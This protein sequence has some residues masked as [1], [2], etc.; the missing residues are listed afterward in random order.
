VVK[1]LTVCTGNICRSPFAERYLQT[2]LDELAPGR[3]ELSSAGTQAMV[4]KPMDRRSAEL[5]EQ[6]GGSDDGFQARQLNEM[7]LSDV[8]FV[9]ALTVEHRNVV[10]ARSPRMLKRAFTV[11]EFARVLDAIRADDAVSLPRGGD[12]EDIAA[13]WK[14]LPKLAALKRHQAHAGGDDVVD[15]YRQPSEVYARM[16]DQLLPPLRSIV[17]FEAAA[18]RA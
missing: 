15:P 3:F 16:I 4:G 13:R 10:L 2:H 12:P 18:V 7:M 8:D 1:I 11:R 17:E 14:A 6:A 5:L 9:L